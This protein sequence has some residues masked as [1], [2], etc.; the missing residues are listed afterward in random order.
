AHVEILAGEEGDRDMRAR[1][2]DRSGIDQLLIFLGGDLQG[3]VVAQRLRGDFARR[4]RIGHHP[5]SVLS[6]QIFRPGLYGPTSGRSTTMA[7]VQNW[8]Q[9]SKTAPL[10]RIEGYVASTPGRRKDSSLCQ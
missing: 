1:A 5:V 3:V 7:A 10:R 6:E 2:D 8:L 9:C 4:S